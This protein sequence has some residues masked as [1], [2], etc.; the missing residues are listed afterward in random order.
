MNLA[1]M[2]RITVSSSAT[3]PMWGKRSLTGIP[4]L[5]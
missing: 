5:P 1:V 3:L 4:L 2:E